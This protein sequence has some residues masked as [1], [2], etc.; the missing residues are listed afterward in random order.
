V[1]IN[2]TVPAAEVTQLDSRLHNTGRRTPLLVICEKRWREGERER[3]NI[4]R[5]HGARTKPF[6]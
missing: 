6:A 3:D 5:T 2:D 4:Y 1:K